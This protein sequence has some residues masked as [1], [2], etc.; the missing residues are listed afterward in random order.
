MRQLGYTI[1]NHR[2]QETEQQRA[3]RLS[4]I[5]RQIE[6]GTY[7]NSERMFAALDALLERLLPSDPHAGLRRQPLRISKFHD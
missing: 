7:D 1:V 2:R 4:D 3:A 5:R 6:A